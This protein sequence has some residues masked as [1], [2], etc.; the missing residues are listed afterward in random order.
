M[1]RLSDTF[2]ELPSFLTRSGLDV[3]C[4]LQPGINNMYA[5]ISNVTINNEERLT[6]FGS[7]NPNNQ[8][9]FYLYKFKPDT[10][11]GPPVYG[12]VDQTDYFIINSNRNIPFDVKLP[13]A[14]QGVIYDKMYFHHTELFEGTTLTFVRNIDI[15]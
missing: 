14:D 9:V 5:T 15:N 8:F 12:S 2:V 6:I 1:N 4:N 10:I 13:G 3:N 7:D 11:T